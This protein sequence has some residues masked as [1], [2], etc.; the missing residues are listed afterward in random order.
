MQTITTTP[1]FV[2]T[3]YRRAEV[4]YNT[5]GHRR[6]ATLPCLLKS[7]LFILLYGAAYGFFLFGS[8]QFSTMLGWAAL[9]GV[10]HV[11]IPVNIA[12]DAIHGTLSARMWVNHLGLYGLE[13]TGAN[14]Y[15]YRKKHLEAHQNKEHGKGV[16]TIEAQGL[17]LQK[18]E[19]NKTVNLPYIFYLF[20]AE[21]MIFVRD[22]QLFRS[23]RGSIP[24]REWRKLYA[25]KALYAVAFL[26]LPFVFID[27][28][29]WQI[30]CALL[31]MYFI[32]T[33]L[34]VIILLMPTEKME[35]SK[36][37][38]NDH[39]ND[40]WAMEILAH[41]VDFSPASRLLNYLAG[42]ANLNVVHYL[43]PG[44]NH[45]HY[46]ALAILVEATAKEY[47]LLYRKQNVMDVLGIH[48]N[49]LKNI[50]QQESSLPPKA[51]K[52]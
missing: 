41:N 36:I 6:F 12:H 51:Q 44:T 29:P 52:A 14:A 16:N 48:F 17:L 32:V 19:N 9:L 18:E 13:I 46:N 30:F 21:Y 26:M 7:S 1:G 27:L 4:Y 33:V 37:A 45:I 11:L 38:G 49:Y 5:Q 20:Y 43:F 22:F 2:D 24:T 35:H 31:L 39:Y 8:H 28:P 3:L 10:C 15:M 40:Q 47:D 23:Y 25:T 50:Q 42:G 34:L